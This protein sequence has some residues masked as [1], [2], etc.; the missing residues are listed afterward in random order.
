MFVYGRWLDREEQA[1]VAQMPA[2]AGV[3]RAVL[4]RDTRGREGMVVSESRAGAPVV[5]RLVEV[6]EARLRVLE[7]LHGAFG[8][9]ERRTIRVTAN[10]QVVQA[11]AWVLPRTPFPSEGWSRARRPRAQA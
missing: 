11:E 8:G 7:L 1:W 9:L 2:R 3:V 5:G 10:M 4:W 6:D